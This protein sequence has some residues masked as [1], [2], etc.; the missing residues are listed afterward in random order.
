MKLL[1]LFGV[2]TLLGLLAV[3]G[4]TAVLP[5]MQHMTVHHFHWITDNQFRSIYSI[6]QVAPGPNML[7]VMLIGYK[8]AGFR[9]ASVVGVGFFLPDC[10][11]TLFANRL[12]VHF[13]A[14]PWRKA[15]QRG[16]APVAIGLM[17]AGTAAIAKLAIVDLVSAA[18]A[19]TVFALLLWRHVNPALIIMA[20]G[21]IYLLSTIA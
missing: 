15:I 20:G 19:I 2:F 1:N 7:M 14:S 4:G 8:L 11:L 10:I 21:M 13:A 9:G 3:G 6:G 5:E 16:M 18:I 12:W 17:A